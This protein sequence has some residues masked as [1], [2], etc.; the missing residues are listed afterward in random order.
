MALRTSGDRYPS[1]LGLGM[2][3]LSRLADEDP[4]GPAGAGLGSLV[5]EEEAVMRTD[6]ELTHLQVSFVLLL[7][8][9]NYSPF[10]RHSV[11]K[12][13]EQI[14]KKKWGANEIAS[15]WHL[16]VPPHTLPLG[17]II[18]CHWATTSRDPLDSI[19]RTN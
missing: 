4:L 9:E 16:L 6:E 17:K 10:R 11:G 13:R 15:C 7:L 14:V 2:A 19:S 5:A 8:R 3:L 1:P 18:T 12:H